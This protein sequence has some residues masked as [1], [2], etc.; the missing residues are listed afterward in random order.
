MMIIGFC[1]AIG[2]H[3]LTGNSNE[4][5]TDEEVLLHILT[6][7]DMIEEEAFALNEE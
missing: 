7:V 5:I 2:I 3:H 4:P 1:F 6:M